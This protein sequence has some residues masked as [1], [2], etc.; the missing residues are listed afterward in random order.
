MLHRRARQAGLP[1]LHPHQFRHTFAHQ[2]L[3]QGG[4]EV[5]LVRLAGWRFGA[6][7]AVRGQHR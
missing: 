6:M 1:D 4:A 7:V 2:C 5:D 3:A